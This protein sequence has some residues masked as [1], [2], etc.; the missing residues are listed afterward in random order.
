LY[1]GRKLLETAVLLFML[2]MFVYEQAGRG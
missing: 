2:F 1:L